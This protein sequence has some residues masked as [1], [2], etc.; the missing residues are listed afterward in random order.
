MKVPIFRIGGRTGKA[1]EQIIG[2]M[3]GINGR[4]TE[5]VGLFCVKIGGEGW[6][7]HKVEGGFCILAGKGWILHKVEVGFCILDE[8]SWILHKIR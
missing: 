6:I 3:S 2:K 7:L 5:E 1:A 4:L 8:K